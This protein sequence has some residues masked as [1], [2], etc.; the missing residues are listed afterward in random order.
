V[1]TKVG[2]ERNSGAEAEKHTQTI[3]DH[4][5]KG[6]G[7]LVDECCGEEV[8]QS[9]Q[10]PD[11]NEKCVVDDRVCSVGGA[12]NVVASHCCDDNSTEELRPLARSISMVRGSQTWKA[13][14]PIPSTRDTILSFELCDV[15]E[16][17]ELC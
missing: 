14:R 11:T 7:E 13:R 2:R 3:H 1:S 10:P 9:E 15:I 4:I 8:Q 5:N 17:G 16:N 6:N 12:R